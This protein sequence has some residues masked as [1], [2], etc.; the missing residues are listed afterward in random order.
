LLIREAKYWQ[1]DDLAR[2]LEDG[3]DIYMRDEAQSSSQAGEKQLVAQNE[4]NLSHTRKAVTYKNKKMHRLDLSNRILDRVIINNCHLHQCDF[5]SADMREASLRSS[6]IV[7]A[8]LF[9]AVLDGTDFSG[10]TVEN[11]DFSNK[12]LNKCCFKDATLINCNFD[13]AK[14]V[15]VDLSSCTIN[16]CSF[17][18]SSSFLFTFYLFFNRFINDIVEYRNGRM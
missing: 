3:K 16:Q 8:C 5:T 12:Q 1:L 17:N 14:L 2:S 13:S 10:S 6:Q 7:D 4:I 15:D 11:I 9:D 18:A